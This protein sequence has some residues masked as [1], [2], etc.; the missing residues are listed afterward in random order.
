MK[1]LNSDIKTKEVLDW[2]GIHL[3]N[4]QYSACSMKTRIYLNLKGIPF[5]SHQIDLTSGENF[6]DWFQGINPRSLVPVLIHD[7]DVHIES[8][9]ILQYLEK[10]YKENP[11]TPKDSEETVNELLRFENDLHE[12][13]R[14][15][16]F[17]FMVPRILNKGHAPKPKSKNKATLHGEADLLDDKNRKYW[18]DYKESGIT[19]EN[20]RSSLIRLKNALS[21][22]DQNLH[23]NDFILGNKLS[24]IDIAWFVYVTRLTY[25]KYP[26]KDLHP[27]VYIWHKRLYEKEVFRK[28]VE[29]PLIMKCVIN[30]NGVLLDLR[31]KGI[32]KLLSA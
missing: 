15:V 25:V 31:N 13:I 23:I 27:N 20:V 24:L 7:G 26:L 8:N 4:F 1:L 29:I 30:A 17:K 3:I 6:S 28:E 22:I 12:D 16:T 18:E 32:K 9:D 11:L 2:K 21:E 19:D 14:N 10:S 5:T